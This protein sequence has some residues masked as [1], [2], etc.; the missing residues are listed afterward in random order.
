MGKE[1]GP[2]LTKRI[3]A[4]T[5]IETRFARLA[6]IVRGGNPTL[7]DRVMATEMGV[8][9]VDELLRG[10]SNLVICSRRGKVVAT[11]IRYALALDDLYK[12]FKTREDLQAEFSEWEIE[13]MEIEVEARHIYVKNLYNIAET[14]NI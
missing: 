2:A 5:G 12:G 14:V 1:Y 9:A 6:H 13:R 4:A 3:E 10:N 7:A 11:E 8:F